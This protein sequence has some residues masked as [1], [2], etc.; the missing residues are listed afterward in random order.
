MDDSAPPPDLAPPGFSI[1]PAEQLLRLPGFWPAYYVPTWDDFADEPE[2][3]G[4]DG[5]DVDAAV[6]ALYGPVDPW[7]AY[8]LPL[9]GGHVLWIVH[10]NHPEDSGTDYVIT[11]P[12]WSRS[13][14][15]ASIEGHFSGP[16]LS[17]PELPAVAGSAPPGAEGVLDPG[18][19][20]LLLLP[21]FG[22]ADVP[23]E[24]AVR[25]IAD[26]LTGA[27]MAAEA[28]PGA[29][30]RFLDHPFWDG[31]TWTPQGPSPLSG[32]TREPSPLPL[33]DG[34]YS[35][36]TVRLAQGITADQERALAA[37]LT[38]RHPVA[39]PDGRNVSPSPGSP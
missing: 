25:R 37:A 2:L 15:P 34:P 18:T 22:D 28:A 26:A 17:W 1:A 24:E 6:D 4:A 27:G 32:T 11:H 23:T 38:V 8:R 36:R 20:L 12:A 33:C 3:F 9:A 14:R 10:S 29:A 21:A 7:P 39:V 35:P 19:R 16:G 13:G 5:A 31:P 30:V